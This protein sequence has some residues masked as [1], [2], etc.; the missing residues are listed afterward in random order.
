MGLQH[1]A[2]A[3]LDETQCRAESAQSA[4]KPSAESRSSLE[5][6][7]ASLA[8]AALQDTTATAVLGVVAGIA[9]VTGTTL[10][11]VGAIEQ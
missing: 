2:A 6:S 8:D 1:G 11:V 7:R 5:A 3:P 9:F 4:A 10:L